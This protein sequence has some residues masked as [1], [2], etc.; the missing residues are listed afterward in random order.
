MTHMHHDKLLSKLQEWKEIEADRS[1]EVGEQREDMK[2]FLELT[3]WNKKA[4]A[5]IR[6]L[7]KMS[8]EKRDDVLRSFDDLRNTLEP[9][10]DGQSTPDMLD[11]D[12]VFSGDVP[13]D[14]AA[15]MTG[16]EAA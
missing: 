13:A 3:G 2:N 1:S 6:A 8:Q 14:E 12:G 7:D 9:H 16:E 5:F 15:A 4:L 10:W 11:D